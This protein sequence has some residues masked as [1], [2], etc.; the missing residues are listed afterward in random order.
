ML[1]ETQAKKLIA[2]YGVHTVPGNEVDSIGAV[3]VAAQKI[4]MPVVLKVSDPAVVHKSDAGGVLLD[5]GTEIKVR[6]GA[7]F[8]WQQFGGAKLRVEKQ[9][10][11]GGIDLIL[12]FNRDP[13]F[14]P[15]TMVGM[16]GIYAELMA[17][18]SLH[19][20]AVSNDDAMRMIRRLKGCPILEG[21]RGRSVMDLDALT[22][23]IQAVS[24][25]AMGRPDIRELDINPWRV[26]PKGGLALDA[27]AAIER[28]T[29]AIREP[30]SK[31][32][33]RSRVQPL[34]S[35][36]SVAIVGGSA[37][38]RKAGNIIID[39]L[40]TFGFA[41]SIYPVHRSG[42]IIQG[43]P[44][45]PRLQDCPEP[46]D[47]CV[48]AVPYHQVNAIMADIVDADIHH[49][50]IVSGGFSDAG[51]R[52]RELE[53]ELLAFC[54]EHGIHLMGP[55][56]IGTVDTASGF[57]TSIGT[58]PPMKKTGIAIFGQS[59][60]FATG[61]ALEEITCRKRGF[62][63]IACMG[64][65]ADINECDFLE[66]FAADPETRSIG[67]YIESVTDGKRFMDAARFAASRKPLLVLKSGRTE[68]GARAAASHTGAL[69]G[70]DAV[71]D[72]VFRQVGI[73][74]AE[75]LVDFFNVLRAFDMCPLPRGN[76][77]GVVSITGLG[78]VLSADACGQYGMH[79][80]EV[81]EDTKN[82]LRDL[83]PEWAPIGNP[84][85]IWSTIE[86]H[87]PFEAY[88]RM[89]QIMLS[90]PQVDLLVL[91]V[92]LLDEGVFDA[93]EALGEVIASYPEKPVLACH[94]GG[95]K[96]HLEKF[97]QDM[98]S[99]GVPVYN[100]PAMAVKYGSFLYQR[101]ILE[102][103]FRKEKY[104]GGENEHK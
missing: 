13:V 91:I 76:R 29:V 100:S 7:E 22:E 34:F 69:A 20:G 43:L 82:R 77:I 50:I 102:K 1:T 36:K 95:R 27:M 48:V 94:M 5:L 21:A 52:G 96:V 53:G 14:G 74:R 84:A 73:Q 70:S 87:G 75:H 55:N 38:A 83:V 24:R 90:D 99:I 64:N 17:D 33:G 61:F 37:D 28:D 79:L 19:V 8:L 31:A 25:I 97:E 41:G 93:A 4:G 10:P 85:D 63:K 66:F 16:G 51:S 56:S 54:R 30:E 11:A 103:E 45:Y 23:A 39:N 59:G 32:A 18:T 9:A 72:A 62:S 101:R 6:Q 47:I 71:Y 67:C 81:T 2:E 104:P 15:V 78:C 40:R 49:V 88:R 3:L 42:G 26:Y 68:I 58:L 57:C 80:S 98:A 89:C 35:P 86:Q 92:V 65:K 44:A 12:G 46:V 60:T